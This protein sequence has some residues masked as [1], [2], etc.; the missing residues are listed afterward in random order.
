L[1]GALQRAETL[2]D[3]IKQLH[4]EYRGELLGTLSVSTGLALFPDH[5]STINDVLRA[6]DQALYCA[7]REGRDRV[8]VWTTQSV[9]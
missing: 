2:H 5:G 6:A 9:A 1:Q 8:C 3:Q 7:K 4:A